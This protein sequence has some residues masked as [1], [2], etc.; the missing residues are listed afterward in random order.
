MLPGFDL[1]GGGAGSGAAGG[2]FF[3]C[4]ET[5]PRCF[6]IKQVNDLDGA[7]KEV[8]QSENEEKQPETLS[9][10]GHHH[11]NNNNSSSAS[12][13]LPM[14]PWWFTAECRHQL[15]SVPGPEQSNTPERP[16]SSI[17]GATPMSEL[18]ARLTKQLEFYFSRENLIND[19]YLRC[20][21]D[22]DQYVPIKIVA[23]FPKVAQ[24][25]TDFDLIVDVLKSSSQVQ[26]DES[27]TKVR[28]MS[29]RCTIILR[30]IPQ[31]ADENEVKSMFQSEDG[32]CPP[33]LSLAYG[34]NDSWYVT[35]QTEEET[36]QAFFHL[37]TLGKTFNGKP[38]FARIKNGGAPIGADTRHSPDVHQQ[39]RFSE[40]GI[41]GQLIIHELDIERSTTPNSQHLRPYEKGELDNHQNEVEEEMRKRKVSASSTATNN[42]IVA[43]SNS[44]APFNLGQILAKYGYVPRATF[45]PNIHP[46]TSSVLPPLQ[47]TT[48]GIGTL[49]NGLPQPTSYFT[50]PILR[51]DICYTPEQINVILLLQQQQQ[52]PFRIMQHYLNNSTS[53]SRQNFCDDFDA[54]V[55]DECCDENIE[56]EEEEEVEND[57]NE[58]ASQLHLEHVGQNENIIRQQAK[59]T[60][61]E[62]SPVLVPSSVPRITDVP[63]INGKGASSVPNNQVTAAAITGSIRRIS[64]PPPQTPSGGFKGFQRQE[65]V[66]AYQLAMAANGLNKQKRQ[67]I[68]EKIDGKFIDK[69]INERTQKSIR[70]NSTEQMPRI[71]SSHGPR[72][73]EP[74]QSLSQIQQLCPLSEATISLNWRQHEVNKQPKQQKQAVD[75]R[76]TN[77][78][79]QQQWPLHSLSHQQ[80]QHSSIQ[81]LLSLGQA[82]NS[83]G[84]SQYPHSFSQFTQQLQAGSTNNMQNRGKGFDRNKS[85]GGRDQ[86]PQF[87]G[88]NTSQNIS[89]SYKPRTWSTSNDWLGKQQPVNNEEIQWQEVNRNVN[90]GMRRHQKWGSRENNDGI[91][92]G[93]ALMRRS[94]SEYNV[95]NAPTIV[96]MSN[97]VQQQQFF[98]EKRE[99][100]QQRQ[101]QSRPQY[102]P[103][104]QQQQEELNIGNRLHQQKRVRAPFA[105]NRRE[106]TRPITNRYPEVTITERDSVGQKLIQNQKQLDKVDEQKLEQHSGYNFEE[107]VE[108]F[109]AL[110]L[111]QSNSRKASE[112]HSEQ[113]SPSSPKFLEHQQNSLFSTKQPFS[114]VVAGNGRPRRAT[115]GTS[116]ATTSNIGINRKMNENTYLTVQIGEQQQHEQ[117]TQPR[118]DTISCGVGEGRQLLGQR[119]SYAQVMLKRSGGSV[120]GEE[121]RSASAKEKKKKE[122]GEIS[123]NNDSN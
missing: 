47:P 80:Q 123:I 38:V 50:Q 11:S 71:L 23:N 116:T 110:S 41:N 75:L 112:C 72:R 30:E 108:E 117:H 32:R 31:N 78:Q 2:S 15:L 19:R 44:P 26:V 81:P 45:R 90:T 63:R 102:Q 86:P 99:D 96:C 20:Q 7:I 57:E 13:F 73:S 9:A 54:A 25:S 87:R 52:Y 5:W 62:A 74:P 119:R 10:P 64:S 109:P 35:F 120:T 42:V 3:L 70:A 100:K 24:L 97:N 36:Q 18:R 46:P 79:Q 53:F 37:Q 113:P 34:L 92:K 114:V 51:N 122:G 6:V 58:S 115:I 83:M 107:H 66:E 61:V 77:V 60:G 89:N 69:E 118:S 28:P 105:S 49:M 39:L 40:T 104:H 27:A 67:Q 16:P 84:M 33:Y 1:D 106:A 8:Q 56:G 29:K 95:N 103:L 68:D 22:A 4:T 101:Q 76:T 111:S 48:T 59:E 12:P 21:M 121:D 65:S 93:K 85:F 43:A 88:I 82:L 91:L 94:G 17:C 55:D 14:L 98:D